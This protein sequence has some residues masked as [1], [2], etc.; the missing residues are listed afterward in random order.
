MA[1]DGRKVLGC[2][3]TGVD[4]IQKADLPPNIHLDKPSAKHRL[5]CWLCVVEN[6]YCRNVRISR[7]AAE[8]L[9][10]T[11]QFGYGN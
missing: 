5:Q 1:R 11:G 4:V 7:A 6:G 2:V 9:I 10:A 3:T 8:I